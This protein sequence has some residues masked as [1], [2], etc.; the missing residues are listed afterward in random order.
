M[1]SILRLIEII[2]A[3]RLL[4]P[5]MFEIDIDEAL[6][7]RDVEPFDS[8]WIKAHAKVSDEDI[9]TRDRP[10]L[11][12][13]REAAYLRCYKLTQNS[14]LSGFVAD[15]FGLIGTYLLLDERDDWVNALWCAYRDGHFPCGAL[16]PC[17]G[18][19]ASMIE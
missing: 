16:T 5:S 15:D 3:H 8:D 4:V 12:E 18:N 10:S 1:D 13:L 11:V 9:D 14:E 6:D 17:G 19:L 7:K 2:D